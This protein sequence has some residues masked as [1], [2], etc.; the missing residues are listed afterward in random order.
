[1][2]EEIYELISKE[3]EDEIC[4]IVTGLLLIEEP[5]GKMKVSPNE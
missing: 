1:M 3:I 5:K 2:F 4:D